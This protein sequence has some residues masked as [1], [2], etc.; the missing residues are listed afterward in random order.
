MIDSLG[1][2]LDTLGVLYMISN[3]LEMRPYVRAT[4]EAE[5]EYVTYVHFRKS[6]IV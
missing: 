1:Q 6:K 2:E 4:K 3:T 5:L